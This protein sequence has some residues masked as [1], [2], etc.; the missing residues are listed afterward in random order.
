[1]TDQER[2]AMTCVVQAETTGVVQAAM[3]CVVR[4][5][6]TDQERVATTGPVRARGR[7]PALWCLDP[8]VPKPAWS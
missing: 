4:A 2:A 3:T 8:P 1:M 5:E 6:T 7:G